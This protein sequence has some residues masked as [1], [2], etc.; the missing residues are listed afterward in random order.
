ME[1]GQAD[2]HITYTHTRARARAR[3]RYTGHLNIILLLR[4]GISSRSHGQA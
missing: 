4:N 2:D 3:Y 1:Y